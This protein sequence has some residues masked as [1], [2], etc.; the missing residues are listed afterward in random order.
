K[1][2]PTMVVARVATLLWVFLGGPRCNSLLWVRTTVKTVL[3]C[4]QEAHAHTGFAHLR[5]RSLRRIVATTTRLYALCNPLT[6]GL[7]RIAL[8]VGES[9][10]VETV[11]L[12]L[13][14]AVARTVVNTVV[15]VDGT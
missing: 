11:N 13:R 3:T 6:V 12:V 2:K 1:A 7:T 8:A 4:Q 10:V 9:Q 5:T 14:P 15:V